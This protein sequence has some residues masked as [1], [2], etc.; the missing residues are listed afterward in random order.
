MSRRDWYAM[1]H[2]G[3]KTAGMDEQTR[4]DWMAK[5]TGKRSCKECTDDEL[6]RLCD[7][8]RVQ[9]YLDSGK[10]MGRTDA[11][12]DGP[13]QPTRAQMRLLVVLCKERGWKGI[14]D[15]GF[16]RFVRRVIKVD[17]PRFMTREGARKVIGGL[18]NWSKRDSQ[19]E[20]QT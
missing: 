8:L 6:M 9:G 14:D 13:D 5:H 16:A 20:Q 3:T 11:G 17:S 4:R 19:K 15:P 12:S 7:E 1:V 2:L 18:K 10:P